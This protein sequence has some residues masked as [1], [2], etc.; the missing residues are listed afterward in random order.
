MFNWWKVVRV[1]ILSIF[2]HYVLPYLIVSAFN[3]NVFKVC[4]IQI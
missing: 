3:K 4:Q 2:I 1:S